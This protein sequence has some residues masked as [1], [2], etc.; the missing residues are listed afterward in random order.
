MPWMTRQG[1]Y[2]DSHC[3]NEGCTSHN[4]DKSTPPGASSPSR[5]LAVP[6][7]PTTQIILRRAP[8]YGLARTELHRTGITASSPLVTR[9]VTS[10]RRLCCTTLLPQHSGARGLGG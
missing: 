7:T 5:S 9:R 8:L 1:F 2:I 4:F 10:S 6:S 3:Y